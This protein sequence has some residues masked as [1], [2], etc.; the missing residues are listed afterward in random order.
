[1]TE[2]KP[3]QSRKFLAYLVAE[4]TWK[5]AL[6]VV[7]TLGMKNGTID[8][9]VGSIALAIVLVAGFVEVGYIIGQGSLDKYTRLAEIAV[10][11]NKSMTMAGLTVTH[12]PETSPI[13]TEPTDPPVGG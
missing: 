3:L 10:S 11:N 1:M 4:T 2:S 8:V 6:L 7:L 5:L 9:I 12:H 13:I